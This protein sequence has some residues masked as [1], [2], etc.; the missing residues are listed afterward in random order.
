MTRPLFIHQHEPQHSGN[1]EHLT[2]ASLM[3]NTSSSTGIFSSE[4]PQSFSNEGEDGF[5]LK[6]VGSTFQPEK[7]LTEQSDYIQTRLYGHNRSHENTHHRIRNNTTEIKEQTFYQE[8]QRT[9]VNTDHHITVVNPL[10]STDSQNLEDDIL[11]YDEDNV[12]VIDL[13]D[14]RNNPQRATQISVPSTNMEAPKRRVEIKRQVYY[15]DC[16]LFSPPPPPLDEDADINE[17]IMSIDTGK[18]SST[19]DGV[20]DIKETCS[21][22]LPTAYDHSIDIE[23]GDSGCK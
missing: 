10:A 4:N 22:D 5:H 13:D 8:Q 2:H 12:I 9:Q 18:I 14:M 17:G 6:K 7:M 23:C 16:D 21:Q 15:D 19:N 1:L 3:T 11:E 20:L